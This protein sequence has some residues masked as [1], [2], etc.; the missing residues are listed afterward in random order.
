[1]I[2]VASQPHLEEQQLVRSLTEGDE[3]AF[4]ILVERYHSSLTRVALTYVRDRAVAEEV[5][6][7][8]WLGV[9]RGIERFEQRSSLRTWIFRILA[10][11]ARTRGKHERRTVP[12]S[13]LD[14]N[15]DEPAVEPERFLDSSHARW[16]GHWAS[17]PV[18]WDD[19]PEARLIARETLECIEQTINRLP[20]GQAQVVTLRD[21]E[22]WSSSEVCALLGL[23]EGNQR[24]LL[25]RARSKL[26]ASLEL[27]FAET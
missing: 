15:G 6:Q 19:I 4:G 5:V 26:R 10:N 3:A 18:S 24:V 22:G 23:S 9:L 1:M 13:A 27:H 7:E 17:P 11:K 12:F 20:P 25:H 8:T 14:D 2:E 16:A 21:L